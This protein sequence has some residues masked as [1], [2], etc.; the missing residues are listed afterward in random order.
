M[1]SNTKN[2][3]GIAPTDS[4]H[5]IL[6]SSFLAKLVNVNER[7]TQAEIRM[8]KHFFIHLMDESE[9]ITKKKTQ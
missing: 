3:P 7:A 6:Q 1:K 8:S 2:W 9:S 4:F 5:Q